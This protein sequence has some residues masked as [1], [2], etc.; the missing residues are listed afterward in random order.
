[1]SDSLHD[2]GKA[3]EDQ[4]FAEQDKKL[5]NKIRAEMAAKESREALEHASGISDV[6]VLDALVSI[7]ITPES[8]TSVALIPLVAVA[9]SDNKMENSEKKAILE[10]AKIAGIAPG[11]ASYATLE[12]WLN[13]RPEPKLLEAW[14]AYVHSLK[15]ALETVAYNQLKASVLGRAEDVA[16]SAGGL[17]GLGNKISRSEEKVLEELSKAFD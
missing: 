8:L 17:L 1:M 16:K 3:I 6:T 15:S 11:S 7:D 13:T 4:F 14:K 5:L 10:A 2:R 12:S 9:W